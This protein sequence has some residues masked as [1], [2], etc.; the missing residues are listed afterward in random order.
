MVETAKSDLPVVVEVV[1]DS[2]AGARAAAQAGASRLELCC[3]LAEGGL[4][5]TLGLLQ[6]V[7]RAVDLPV[8]AMLRPRGGDFLYTADELA[9]LRA[10]L[11]QL[12]SAGADG[13]AVGVLVPAGDLDLERL[14]ELVATAQPLPITCHRAFDLVRDADVALDQLLELG[15]A[16][17]LTSGQ[18]PSATAGQERIRTLVQRARG[19]IEVIAAAGVRSDSVR[20]L[21]RRTAVG[22]VHLSASRFVDSAMQHRNPTAT[23]RTQPPNGDYSLRATDGAEVARVVAAVAGLGGGR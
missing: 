3:A 12:A 10:D 18:S 13:F 11:Q 6:Q 22:A 2:V 17:V 5:P 7:K 9:V 8:V 4:T 23:M 20:D 19:R 1:V 14:R 21:V 16:R 15:I